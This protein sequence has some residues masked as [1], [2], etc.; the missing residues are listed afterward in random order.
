MPRAKGQLRDF[1]QQEARES[2]VYGDLLSHTGL[3]TRRGQCLGTSDP[4]EGPSAQAMC[5]F[6]SRGL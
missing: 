5:V 6:M 1:L 2:S 3:T 4:Q